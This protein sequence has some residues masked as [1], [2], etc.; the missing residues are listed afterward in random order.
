MSGW[1]VRVEASGAAGWG[2]YYLD[3]NGDP[4]AEYKTAYIWPTR[5]HA[6][7]QAEKWEVARLELV[8]DPWVDPEIIR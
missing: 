7:Q 5:Q 8:P 3:D 4:T 6:L 1:V 2:W